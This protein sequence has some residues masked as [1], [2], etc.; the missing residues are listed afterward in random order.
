MIDVLE[1]RTP[2]GRFGF[3]GA[4]GRTD[5]DATAEFLDKLTLPGGVVKGDDGYLEAL[6]ALLRGASML[7]AQP[8]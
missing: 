3:V 2:D 7:W 1:L 5:S 4:D 6:Y 8:S